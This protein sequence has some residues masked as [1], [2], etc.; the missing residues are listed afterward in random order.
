MAL[1]EADASIPFHLFRN[2]AASRS[3]DSAADGAAPICKVARRVAITTDHNFAHCGFPVKF[4]DEAWGGGLF[5][6]TCLAFLCD[7]QNVGAGKYL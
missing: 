1:R 6:S 3:F 5:R 7:S 2:V 4:R